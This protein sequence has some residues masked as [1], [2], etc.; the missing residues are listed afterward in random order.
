[1]RYWHLSIHSPQMTWVRPD[2]PGSR[3][4]VE[5]IKFLGTQHY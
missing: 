2:L 1:L 5:I 4:I 3:R